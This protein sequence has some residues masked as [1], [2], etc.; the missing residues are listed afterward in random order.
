ML[1]RGGV[2]R[3]GVRGYFDAAGVQARFDE[4]L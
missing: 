3:V 4:F 1:E 2:D